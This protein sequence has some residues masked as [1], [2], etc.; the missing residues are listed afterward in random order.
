MFIYILDSGLFTIYPAIAAIA[1]VFAGARS[2]I[3]QAWS[4]TW[5]VDLPQYTVFS[6]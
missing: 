1:E 5:E 6:H 2:K 3:R 4:V